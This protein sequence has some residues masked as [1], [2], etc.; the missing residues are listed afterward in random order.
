MSFE[1]TS[2]PARLAASVLAVGMLAGCA[3]G[4][5]ASPHDNNPDSA[6]DMPPDSAPD[7]PD[8]AIAF[9]P[10]SHVR[11]IDPEFAA[12]M[13]GVTLRDY[14][15]CATVDQLRIVDVPYRDLDGKNATGSIVVRKGLA[16]EV[17]DI[18]E[19]IYATGFRINKI[20]PPEEITDKRSSDP[21]VG[22]KIDNEMMDKDV[23]SGFNCRTLEGKAD[24]HG[25][26]SAVD[27]NPLEN[28]M[29]IPNPFTTPDAAKYKYSP[30]T[31][32]GEWDV[33]PDEDTLLARKSDHKT[34]GSKVIDIFK[35][36]GWRW[37][38]DFISLYDGQHF[39]KSAE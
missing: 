12:R 21:Q 23:T 2:L 28:P 3:S 33:N 25:Q 20:A 19:D 30:P 37:G 11:T 17:G 22:V 8:I 16:S 35:Q 13:G 18:F 1:S 7:G 24:K 34:P 32:E 9:A 15:G 4:V 31:A 29:I 5:E 10:E 38:G 14:P 6:V 26:G 27:I 39:D 36:R